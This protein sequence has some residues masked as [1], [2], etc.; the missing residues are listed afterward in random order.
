MVLPF[1]CYSHN[2]ASEINLEVHDSDFLVSNRTQWSIIPCFAQTENT[3][4]GIPYR[5]FRTIRTCLRISSL[6]HFS[7]ASTC[8]NISR[9]IKRRK[10]AYIVSWESKVTLRSRTTSTRYDHCQLVVRDCYL[11]SFSLPKSVIWPEPN[12][13][14]YGWRLTWLTC[15]SSHSRFRGPWCIPV[16][17]VVGKWQL[18]SADSGTLVV[19]RTRTTI[20]RRDFAV[21]GPATWNSLHVELRA[22]SLPSQ[23]FEKNLKN[24]LFG[25]WY[26]W[27]LLF[28]W[29]Y[30]HCVSK[31][32]PTL[33]FA[34]TLTNTDR[35]SKFFHCYIVWKICN[36]AIIKYAT[37]S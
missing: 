4:N 31:K 13:D 37:T 18:W 16:S 21:S 7:M 20:G 36:N 19:P 6:S 22:S 23:T 11:V 12:Y 26:L 1:F 34:V 10:I 33:S 17:S 24:H 5:S 15:A 8:C 2:F 14:P 27:R 28:N 25:C 3:N 32:R 30:I 29:R 35:F 9:S